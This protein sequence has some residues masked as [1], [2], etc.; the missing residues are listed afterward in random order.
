MKRSTTDDERRSRRGVTRRQAIAGGAATAAVAALP[1]IAQS[2][3]PATELFVDDA[4]H[5]NRTAVASHWRAKLTSED[6]FVARLRQELRE[7]RAAKR[8]LAVGAARHSMGG[9]TIPRN[10]SAITFDIAT[11]EMDTVAKRYRTHA[12][13]RWR[14]IIRTLD[15]AGFSP[16]VMQSN[17]D[18]GVAGTL[19]VNAHGWPAPFGPFGETV[20]RFRL[21]LADGAIVTCSRQ[22]NSEL[23]GL[24]TGGYGLFGIILE[25]EVGMA[26]NAMLK[27]FAEV[28]P[29]RE[30]GD[31][32]VRH[33]DGDPKL[34]MA[35]GRMSLTRDAFFEEALLVTYRPDT[36]FAGKLPAAG[37]GGL[38]QG[39]SRVVFRAQEGS[40]R[41]KGLR[42][43]AERKF[44]PGSATRNTLMNEPVSGIGTSGPKGTDILHEYFVPPARFADFV[45]LCRETIPGSGNDLLN[46]TLR[47]LAPDKTSVLAYAPD[48]RIAAVMLF[49]QPRTAEADDRMQRMT[50]RMID[51]VLGMGGAFY[52]PYRL[53]ARR[54]QIEKAYPRLD[55]FI[56]AKRR[57]D[58]DQLF[59]NMMWDRYFGA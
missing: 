5:M 51:G 9:Q 28:F 20:T 33:V 7:A 15:A 30:L 32:F 59:R 34:R 52:L 47:Y 48:R 35:Y 11:C 40:E 31:R 13:T 57:Y 4:S 38:M 49:T 24:V 2:R 44:A 16:T 14:H 23:F 17:N 26:E 6:L 43:K 25:V 10:G 50:E 53:H 46:V 36:A 54:D 22:E 12:G 1:G 27:P 3:G 41:W 58:P 19:S 42:W 21:M 45:A 18:F 29:A 37:A 8:P 39:V 55:A 56:D